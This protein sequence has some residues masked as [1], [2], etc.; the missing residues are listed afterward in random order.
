[1]DD[2]HDIVL[3]MFGVAIAAVMLVAGALYLVTRA[4]PPEIINSKSP[5]SSH[6]RLSS[7]LDNEAPNGS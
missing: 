3:A 5:P 2:L 4:D 1:M 7:G 6:P